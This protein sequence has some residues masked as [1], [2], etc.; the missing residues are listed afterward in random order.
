MNWL[1]YKVPV[2]GALNRLLEAFTSLKVTHWH[3]FFYT[4]ITGLDKDRRRT[5]WH[6]ELD[7]SGG[8]VAWQKVELFLP[9]L[10]AV[11]EPISHLWAN[12]GAAVIL[13]FEWERTRTGQAQVYPHRPTS[14]WGSGRAEDS[15]LLVF[16]QR[17]MS[18][19]LAC[20]SAPFST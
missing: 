14:H 4:R 5:W 2:L 20:I 13:V 11:Q 8:S 12:L 9:S 15:S 1:L 16:V 17:E 19:V 6:D 10:G 18:P 7:P 3:F